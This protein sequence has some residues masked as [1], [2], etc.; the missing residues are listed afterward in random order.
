[1]LAPTKAALHITHRAELERREGGAAMMAESAHLPRD[2]GRRRRT[3][4]SW[5][6]QPV[7][8]RQ[9]WRGSATTCCS[10]RSSRSWRGSRC[11]PLIRAVY[12]AMTVPAPP[13]CGGRNSPSRRWSMSHV[14]TS[15]MFGHR[16]FFS[17]IM[18]LVGWPVFGQPTRD[19]NM[20]DAKNTRCPNIS[21]VFYDAPRSARRV[22]KL[23]LAAHFSYVRLRLPS[24]SSRVF[25]FRCRSSGRPTLARF[26]WLAAGT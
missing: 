2:G 4:P 18:S 7:A 8:G 26:E 16:V 11:R 1:M 3:S 17:P 13:R 6:I 20:I 15:E 10:R 9:A 23:A 25:V 5:D 14:I 19:M 24:S 22:G 21:D 12:L